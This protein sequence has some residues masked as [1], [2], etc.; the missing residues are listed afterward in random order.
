MHVYI[1][2]RR[3]GDK[4]YALDISPAANTALTTTASGQITPKF[5]WMIDGGTTNFERLG[6]TWSDPV[7]ATIGTTVGS[8]SNVPVYISA[9]AELFKLTTRTNIIEM[10]NILIVYC[11]ANETSF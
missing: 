2:M 5:L 1:A 9:S 10:T 6:Q 11:I 8:D 7:L 3:G 4:I